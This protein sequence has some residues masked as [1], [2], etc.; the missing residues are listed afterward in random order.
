MMSDSGIYFPLFVDLR[1]KQI[2]VFG[3]GKIAARRILSLLDFGGNIQVVSLTCTGEIRLLAEKKRIVY[4]KR[5]Y[6]P[7]EIKDPYIVLAAT[8]DLIVNNQIH[9]EC[10]QK[11]ILVNV[12]SD[13]KKS[14][15]FFPGIAKRESI[16]IGI[17]ASGK[18]HGK[19][20]RITENIKEILR[21]EES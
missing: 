4:E 9:D 19:A 13:Q 12:A 10:K 16:V 21:N 14:D 17:T 18:D 15:F 1:K 3:G 2:V 8:N 11:G 7:G 5:A 20:K 6:V